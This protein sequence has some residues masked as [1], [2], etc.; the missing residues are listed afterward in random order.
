ML[1][2]KY[3]WFECYVNKGKTKIIHI[4]KNLGFAGHCLRKFNI[5]MISDNFYI[6]IVV[7]KSDD[8]IVWS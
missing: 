7:F 1:I 8:V 6:Y 4:I 3:N 2:I 5:F